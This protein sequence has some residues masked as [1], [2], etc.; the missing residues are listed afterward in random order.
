[1]K[2]LKDVLTD[3]EGAI[4]AGKDYKVGIRDLQAILSALQGVVPNTSDP[5]RQAFP[6]AFYG[7]HTKG[8]TFREYLIAKAIAGATSSHRRVIKDAEARVVVINAINLANVAVM[9]LQAEAV[10]EI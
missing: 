8:M 7:A 9:F 3:I 1:M 2:T 4:K 5:S 10:P 6:A